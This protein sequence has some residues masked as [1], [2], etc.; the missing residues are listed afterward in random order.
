MVFRF[1]QTLETHLMKI[2]NVDANDWDEFI[3]PVAF[4]YRI[5]KQAFS[6]YSPFEV[7]YGVKPS[8]PLDLQ[9]AS[10]AALGW[11][12]TVDEAA[13]EERLK[14]FVDGLNPIR[15]EARKNIQEAQ[16]RQNITYNIKHSA[17]AFQVF[18]FECPLRIIT[19]GP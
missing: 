5:N 18:I 15:V 14:T 3:Q 11:D 12:N 13:Q 4:A 2:V 1:N 19:F 17:R 8:I 16:Q 9:T 7:M 6:K 10:T